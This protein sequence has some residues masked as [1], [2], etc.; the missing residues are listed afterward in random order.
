MQHVLRA[1]DLATDARRSH[2]E[3][4]ILCAQTRFLQRAIAN[5][6]NLLLR[7]RRSLKRTY[8][9]GKRD[10]TNLVRTMDATNEKLQ[11]TMGMLRNTPVEAD[12]RPPGEEPRN[13]MDFVDEQSVHGMVDALK[14]CLGELQAIQTSYDGD[15]LRFDND[16]RALKKSM[17]V[18]LAPLSAS[19]SASTAY[20]PIPELLLS[21]VEHSHGMAQILTSLT[22]HFDLC[23]TAVRTTEGGAD[24]AR[25]RAAEVT[26]SQGG[27]VVSISG[28]IA[29]QE[30]HMSGLEPTTAEER[31]DMINV[32]VD[33][34]VQVETA[35]QE[36]NDGLRAVM[37]DSTALTQ[38]T[39]HIKSS[40]VATATALRALEE[41]GGRFAGYLAAE[42]EFLQR[43][44]DERYTIYGK[45][46]EMDDLREFYE[47]YAGAYDNLLL[48]VE[49]RRM[50]E[51]K[52]QSIWRKARENV[53]KLA[54]SDRQHREGF[55]HDVGEFIPTDLWP[56]MDRSM[57][58]WELVPSRTEDAVGGDK[59]SGT[60]VLDQQIVD[61]A[62]ERLE[63]SQP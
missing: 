50:V 34:A 57:I 30:S 25:R 43:W 31:A 19:P 54:E 55:R 62:R 47:R 32:V 8:D 40:Y 37:S 12:F 36:I 44:E 20:E 42:A 21:L 4:A 10:F 46:S 63:R 28:V 17:G 52:I 61:A 48:E 45:L 2:E 27:D 59:H 18:S 51:D 35:V 60:P 15:L 29:D 39:E 38:Q 24:L 53:D 49:R 5:Q 23:V 14:K 22:Q 56:G 9:A 6:T 1:N 11:E 26:Q 41:I 3:A 7:V 58:R 13:L 33:D 16:L